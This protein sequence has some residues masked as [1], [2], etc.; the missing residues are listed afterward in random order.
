MHP[1]PRPLAAALVR[2]CRTA[3]VRALV[4]VLTAVAALLFAQPG[5]ARAATARQ[6]PVPTAPMGWASWNRF[7]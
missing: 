1:P 6:I 4:L 2:R 7:A 3:A 5:P